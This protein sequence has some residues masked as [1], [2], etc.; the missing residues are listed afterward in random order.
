VPFTRRNARLD[1]RGE[2]DGGCA[3]VHAVLGIYAV[4]GAVDGGDT[5]CEIAQRWWR[6]GPRY[7]SPRGRHPLVVV[8][9][10]FRFFM[11]PELLTLVAIISAVLLLIAGVA[12]WWM[13]RAP[14]EETDE[15]RTIP[16][17]DGMGMGGGDAEG[18]GK[19]APAG[20]GIM[21]GGVVRHQSP[22]TI[23]R[24]VIPTSAM[25]TAPMSMPA[26][27]TP[28][29][30]F[31]PRPAAR[32]ADADVVSTRY[33]PNPNVRTFTTGPRR[34]NDPDTAARDAS[35]STDRNAPIQKPEHN[36]KSSSLN[37]AHI[38]TARVSPP[39]DASNDW[40]GDNK[41]VR[42]SPP[43]EGTL[44]FLPG[45]MLVGSGKD[46]GREL[47]FVQ[48]PSPDGTHVTFGRSEGEQYR[49]IQMQDQTVSRMHAELRFFEGKWFLRNLSQTN[50]VMLDGMPLNTD[51]E[52]L[53]DDGARIEMGEVFFIF[54][55]R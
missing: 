18:W 38:P 3:S 36:E 39:V 1:C 55:K 43:A 34:Q 5:L 45:R 17:F 12:V 4:T 32:N 26:I 22:D 44:Q 7:G 27:P 46:A 53:L 47:R 42:F 28:P 51:A 16:L 19:T 54:K 40:G 20:D 48:L 37:T 9:A 10:R 35:N 49:H 52:S 30:D 21:H 15:E 11:T 41:P 50:P 8:S 13:N 24:A 23:D 31:A 29:H 6:F 33:K 25:P 2:D 14:V